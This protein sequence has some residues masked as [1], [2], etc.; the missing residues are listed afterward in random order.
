MKNLTISFGLVLTILGAIYYNA[1]GASGTNTLLPAI[2]GIIIILLGFLQGKWEH[3]HPLYGSLIL[4]VFVLIGSLRALFTLFKM[5]AGDE[6]AEPTAVIIRSII[7]ILCV[8]FI[9]LGLTLIKDFW[10]GWKAFG[11]FLGDLLA[12]VVLTVFYFTVFVPFGIGVKLFSDP[13]HIKTTASPFWRPR[14]TGDQ[15]IEDIMRQF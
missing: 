5:L 14:T 11:H 6:V 2:F 1:A 13:L 15:K 10:R 12:R 9:V 8:V 4:S 3:K 7:G